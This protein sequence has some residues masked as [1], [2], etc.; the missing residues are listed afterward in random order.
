MI[1]KVKKV[2]KNFE[3]IKVFIIAFIA[4]VFANYF[5]NNIIDQLSTSGK[6]CDRMIMNYWNILLVVSLLITFAILVRFFELDGTEE[7]SINDENID[8]A[9][10]EFLLL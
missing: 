10:I 1:K 8:I 2:N 4:F 3:N 6:S 9:L 5:Y 7:G